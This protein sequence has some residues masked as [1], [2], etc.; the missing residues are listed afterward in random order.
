MEL[1]VVLDQNASLLTIELS[2]QR[3]N[4]WSVA[5]PL[6]NEC[7]RDHAGQAANTGREEE[8]RFLE[9]SSLRYRVLRTRGTK[10]F[11]R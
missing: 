3:R 2:G 9:E 6:D 10:H 1:P 4:R 8:A 11:I 5:N 7:Q